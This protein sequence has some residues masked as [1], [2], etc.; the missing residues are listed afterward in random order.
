[1]VRNQEK[2]SAVRDPL[3]NDEDFFISKRGA[4]RY[5]RLRGSPL[6]VRVSDHQNLR[7]VEDTCGKRHTRG[8]HNEAVTAEDA[9]KWTV[10]AVDG[11]KIRMSL[12]EEH[13]GTSPTRK[14]RT[15][16][17]GVETIIGD[18]CTNCTL[19]QRRPTGHIVGSLPCGYGCR[20]Q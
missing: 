15:T 5:I 10:T 1:V 9:D 11:M 3:A 18:L 14:R 12:I 20:N 4:S 8:F 13:S 2:R 16:E 6:N 7:S 17:F 19:C